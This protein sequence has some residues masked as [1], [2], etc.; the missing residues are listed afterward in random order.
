LVAEATEQA[1]GKKGGMR[2]EDPPPRPVEQVANRGFL[3]DADPGKHYVWVSEVNDPTLNVGSYKA[4]GYTVSQYDEG[5][6]KPTIGY[7]EY[8]QGDPIKSMGMVLME[9]SVER[10]RALDEVGWKKADQI[11]ETIR[12]RDIDPLSPEERAS[13]KGIKSVRADNDDRRKWQF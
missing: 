10:K 9:I 4:Q 2:R 6:V 12:Q 3:A 11:Q 8:K 13:F 5:E 1:Q 7:Q